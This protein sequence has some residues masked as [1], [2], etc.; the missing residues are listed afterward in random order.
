MF[1]LARRDRA[2]GAAGSA[3]QHHPAD[4]LLQGLFSIADRDM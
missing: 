3:K 1:A 4:W 2:E